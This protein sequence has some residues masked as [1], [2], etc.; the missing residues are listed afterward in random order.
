MTDLDE[1]WDVIRGAQATGMYVQ[2]ALQPGLTAE[3]RAQR[4][5]IGDKTGTAHEKVKILKDVK[6]KLV[7]KQAVADGDAAVVEVQA[8]PPIDAACAVAAVSMLAKEVKKKPG[9][10]VAPASKAKAATKAKAKA[11]AKA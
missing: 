6:C 5:A 2:A 1:L 11:K 10:P 4:F 9:K 3:V 8:A 7:I